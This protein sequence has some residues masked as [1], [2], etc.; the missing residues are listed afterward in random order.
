LAK[1]FLTAAQIEEW[2]DTATFDR[3]GEDDDRT[4]VVLYDFDHAFSEKPLAPEQEI[5]SVEEVDSSS[6]ETSDE[7]KSELLV[8]ETPQ[9][10][11]TP[12]VAPPPTVEA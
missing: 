8:E 7:S 6:T 3:Q 2:V 12:P 9:T 4:L 5:N 10:V 11:V 1:D